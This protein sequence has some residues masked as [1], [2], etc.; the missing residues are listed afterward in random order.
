MIYIFD[1]YNP[2]VPKGVSINI[3]DGNEE[4]MWEWATNVPAN[5]LTDTRPYLSSDHISILQGIIDKWILSH[6]KEIARIGSLRV[7]H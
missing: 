2:L 3:C 5:W 7:T 6:N 1:N 4:A